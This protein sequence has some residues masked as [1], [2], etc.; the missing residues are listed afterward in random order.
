MQ[1]MDASTVI[2]AISAAV[3]LV[4][5]IVS[6][7]VARSQIKVARQQQ[8]L[9][10]ISEMLNEFHKPAFKELLSYVTDQLELDL[11]QPEKAFRSL[12]V[13]T[14]RKLRPLTSYFNE[15]GLLVADRAISAR[16]VAGMMGGSI[17]ESWQVLAPYIYA[18]RMERDNDPNYYA[19]FEHLAACIA[20][21]DPVRL[22]EELNLKKL[23]PRS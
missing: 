20:D 14:R 18:R 22:A 1:G 16:M 9:P 13:E 19:Y 10:F 3:S 2:A 7:L 5:I 12:D 4:A 23:P 17:A 11:P 21:L 6:S 8:L 15:V